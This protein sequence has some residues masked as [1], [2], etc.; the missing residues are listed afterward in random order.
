MSPK[1]KLNCLQF[2]RLIVFLLFCLR[3]PAY[4]QTKPVPAPSPYHFDAVDQLFKQNQKAL[5]N[6][7][8]LVWKDGKIIYQKQGTQDFSAKN[9]APIA[10]AGDWLTA[11][12]VMTYVDDG[13][14]S[15]DDKVTKFIPL[16]GKYMKGYITI[17]NCLTH[18][19]GIRGDAEGVMK[20]LQKSKFETL[21]EEVNSY[22][23]KRDIVANPGTEFSYSNIGP[24]IAARVL[25]V[26]TKKGFD[27]LV[28]E[29]LLRPLKM[30]GTSFANEDG[31][32][33]NPAGGARS[34][35]NDYI[36]FLSMLLNKGMFGDKRVLS[37][38]SV[39]ELETIQFAS[40]PVKFAPKT[41][42]GAHFT[43]G[44]YS[45]DAN[46]SG[47]PTVFICPNLLGTTPFMDKCR[48]YAAILIVEKPVAAEEQKKSLYLSMKNLVDGEIPCQ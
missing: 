10:G 36:N 26:I 16:F 25:E 18:T 39:A 19:T 29:R 33:V 44:A 11:A 12:V 41:L 38:K 28:M 37:E 15:L 1:S 27:R 21:E 20:V 32:A 31:G 30:R 48:N 7:V 5:G 6:F 42:Q 17:R 45:L 8:A 4:S 43:L 46:S 14:L 3:L 23:S 47:D 24:N 9:P 40:L 34:T 2:S 13:K 35:A 22:A